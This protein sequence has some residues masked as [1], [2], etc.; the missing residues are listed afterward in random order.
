MTISTTTVSMIAP[1]ITALCIT[2]L[3]IKTR[4]ILGMQILN[5]TSRIR[6]ILSITSP[7]NILIISMITLRI[8]TVNILILRMMS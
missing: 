3:G 6:I 1:S 5:T 4:G 8:T 2:T 7:R